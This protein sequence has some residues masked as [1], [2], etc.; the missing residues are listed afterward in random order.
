MDFLSAMRIK[1]GKQSGDLNEA[2]AFF[3][4]LAEGQF[5]AMGK[6][7]SKQQGGIKRKKTK[8]PLKMG[9]TRKLI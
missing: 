5:K 1:H 8:A 4:G 2:N 7:I 6:Q 9:Q 3:G